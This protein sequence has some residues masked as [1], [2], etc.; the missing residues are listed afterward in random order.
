MKF[1]ESTLKNAVSSKSLEERAG[2]NRRYARNDFGKWTKELLD[3]LTFSSVLDACC[4]TGNQLVLYA[5]MPG[6]VDITGVD[7]SRESIIAATERLNGAGTAARITLKITGME[8]MF[9]EEGIK[10]RSFD[11]VS[12]FYGLYYSK[13]PGAVLRKMVEHTSDNG[14]ILIVGPYGK[15]NSSIF[16]L[17]ERHFSLPPEVKRSCTVFM[18]EAVWPVLS[19]HCRV[20]K[21][22]FVNKIS[23]PDA[24][25]LMDYWRATTFYS[26][27]HEKAVL[28]ELKGHFDGNDEFVVEKHV[29]ALIAKKG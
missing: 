17:L 13:D 6:A 3:G 16:G 23:Y 29:L 11:L 25:T 4:G 24:D 12:C 2:A 26:P 28:R 5:A 18:E 19:G 20:E 21:K 1:N 8:E 27:E 10:G 22:I 9:G 7:V 15:N 14:T